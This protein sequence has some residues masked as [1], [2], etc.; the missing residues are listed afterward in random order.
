MANTGCGS[1]GQLGD[2]N[3]VQ[4]RDHEQNQQAE[5]RFDHKGRNGWKKATIWS[6]EMDQAIPQ[7]SFK[8]RVNN[9]WQAYNNTGYG[10]KHGGRNP[11]AHPL[12]QHEHYRPQWIF[13][14]CR[15]VDKLY[16]PYAKNQ[17]A[18]HGHNRVLGPREGIKFRKP[19]NRGPPWTRKTVITEADVS[20]N[21]RLKQK[22]AV[23]SNST[24]V[25]GQVDKGKGVLNDG[26]GPS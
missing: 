19:R 5:Y 21:W 20:L 24:T 3:E 9:G 11:R 18:H 16:K 8:A 13:E 4:P 1:E 12:F 17:M 6:E 26:E 25:N 15:W 10:S 14:K 7:K 22:K 2:R 23:R